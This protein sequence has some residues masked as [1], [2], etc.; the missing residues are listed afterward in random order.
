MTEEEK[1][2]QEAADAQAKADAD[3]KAKQEAEKATQEAE[4][5][6][7]EDADAKAAAEAK[8]EIKTS[9]KKH[10]GIF[11]IFGSKKDIVDTITQ[12]SKDMGL[13]DDGDAG[14]KDLPA[15]KE[16]EQPKPTGLKSKLE[17]AKKES[18]ETKEGA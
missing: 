3:E 13:D 11:A 5:K 6:A 7:K 12:A 10:K 4:A 15:F 14:K 1:K 17:K 16:V 8:E 2:A 18:D 9:A